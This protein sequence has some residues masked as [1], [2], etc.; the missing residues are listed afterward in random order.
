MTQFTN[1]E[2]DLTKEIFRSVLSNLEQQ[3]NQIKSDLTVMK[4]RVSVVDINTKDENFSEQYKQW[5][6]DAFKELSSV[7]SLIKRISV[8]QHK[9]KHRR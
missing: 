8:L 9:V 3:R 2:L 7:T 6:A 1:P 5:R 4:E